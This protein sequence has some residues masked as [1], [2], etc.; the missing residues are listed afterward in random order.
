MNKVLNEIYQIE[1]Q[2]KNISKVIL[3]GSR[4]RGD[5]TDKSDYD[6]AVFSNNLSVSEQFKFL[7]EIDNIDT[8]NK[9]D[10]IFIKEKHIGTE[11]Y[12]NIM[13]DGV[14]IMD[15]FQIK[16]NN[17]KNALKRL[18]DAIEEEKINNSLVVR[19]GA[20]QRFEFTSELAWKTVREF[21][22]KEGAKD[23]NT[24]KNVMQAAFAAD[25]I[26]N[27]EGWLTILRDRNLT[28]HIYD[29]DD[30]NEIFNRITTEH[31]KLFDEL[32]EKLT[33]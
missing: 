13:K 14:V 15:K 25:I 31:I 30:A 10:V 8:L 29:E 22:L 17:Y 9:I 26:T 4:A 33:T 3:F 23:I 27:A 20:I 32:L 19:D 11:L 7:N 21:L 2:Y 1:M 28:S 12:Q 18:H 24:P 16:L 6:I 5:N